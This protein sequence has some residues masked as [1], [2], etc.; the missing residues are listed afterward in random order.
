M[1]DC[2]NGLQAQMKAGKGEEGDRLHSEPWMT[3]SGFLVFSALL[4]S[5]PRSLSEI[6]TS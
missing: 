2:L 6:N 4:P 1:V 5:Q 3:S